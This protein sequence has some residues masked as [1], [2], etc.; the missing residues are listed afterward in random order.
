VGC[1]FKYP[2]VCGKKQGILIVDF[3]ESNK[4]KEFALYNHANNKYF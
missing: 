2:I 3:L 1:F 4:K